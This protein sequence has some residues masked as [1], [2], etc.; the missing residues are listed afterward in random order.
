MESDWHWQ[1]ASIIDKFK[2]IKKEGIN[3]ELWRIWWSICTTRI[4]RKIK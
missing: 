3:Y 2:N 4:K 1:S